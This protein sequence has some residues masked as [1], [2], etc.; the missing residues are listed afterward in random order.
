MRK[1]T[2]V[3]LVSLVLLVIIWAYMGV[4]IFALGNYDITA[5]AYA[6]VICWIVAIA[7]GLCR[8]YN[9]KCP[10]CGK[11]LLQKGRYCPHCGKELKE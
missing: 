4:Q 6:M 7:A 8:T 3:W 9:R 11:R 5:A 2:I 10:H 1:S